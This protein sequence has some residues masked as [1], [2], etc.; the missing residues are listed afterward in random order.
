MG[1]S[2]IGLSRALGRQ[3]VPHL[4]N[5]FGWP[6]QDGSPAASECK[7]AAVAVAEE[8]V[9]ALSG[10]CGEL[11]IGDELPLRPPESEGLPPNIAWPFA[12][13]A[14]STALGGCQ[15]CTELG[16]HALRGAARTDVSKTKGVCK[17]CGQGCTLPLA[18][19]NT[20]QIHAAQA[21]NKD[22]REGIRTCGHVISQDQLKPSFFNSPKRCGRPAGAIFA[23]S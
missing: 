5:T 20:A 22:V 13:T 15:S 21:L 3:S 19:L 16:R 10:S 12:T 18:A 11:S 4:T 23:R 7:A 2:F 1:G 6:E 17:V 8:V 9:A 14:S